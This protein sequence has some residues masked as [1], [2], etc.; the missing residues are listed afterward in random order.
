MSAK[1]LMLTC[2][3][4]WETSGEEDDVVAATQ[5]HGRDVHNMETSRD[6]VL[7]LAKESD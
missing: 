3:C 1:K 7:A 4:G 6:D 2:A 5:E